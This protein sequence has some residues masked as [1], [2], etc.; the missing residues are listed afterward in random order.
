MVGPWC[1]AGG[2][3]R[4]GH[5]IVIVIVLVLIVVVLVVI[6]QCT[7]NSPERGRIHQEWLDTQHVV[8]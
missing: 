7:S 6:L 1:E 3:G 4:R 2:G 5:L 8:W